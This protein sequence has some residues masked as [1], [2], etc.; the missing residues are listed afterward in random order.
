MRFTD[1][2]I[3]GFSRKISA[4]DCANCDSR[5]FEITD[6]PLALMGLDSSK[7]ILPVIVVTC[8]ECG[9]VRLFSAVA[10]GAIRK[11]DPGRSDAH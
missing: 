3:A 8:L 9:H 5:R 6:T 11:A 2:E 7:E 10:L 4:D 1:D